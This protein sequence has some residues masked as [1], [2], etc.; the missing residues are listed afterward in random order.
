MRTKS[1]HTFSIIDSIVQSE[2][3]VQPKIRTGWLLDTLTQFMPARHTF[4]RDTLN[5][6]ANHGVVR[7]TG[8][9]LIE[10][11]SA[12]ELVTARQVV[13]PERKREWMDSERS[14]L[15]PYFY[16]WCQVAPNAQA[17][18]WPYPLPEDTPPDAII[19]TTWPGAAWDPFWVPIENLG[20]I[21][22]AGAV[23]RR[24]KR[25]WLITKKQLR[26]W[27]PYL[28]PLDPGILESTEEAFDAAATWTL[29]RLAIDRL[30]LPLPPF[31]TL[32]A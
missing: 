2:V 17:V 13:D 23:M 4:Q 3:S 31:A 18:P 26:I 32:R 8:H 16:V 10:P 20:A 19:W 29:A 22:F 5:K 24:G 6:W 30:R 11:H 9:G 21:R 15:E 1:K 27:D 14:P 25:H 12:S 7:Q 28:L